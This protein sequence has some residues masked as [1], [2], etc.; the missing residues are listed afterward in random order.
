MEVDMT[1]DDRVYVTLSTETSDYIAE[2]F[3]V[4]A[5][6]EKLYQVG[7]I[8]YRD[9]KMYFIEYGWVKKLDVLENFHKEK[10]EDIVKYLTGLYKK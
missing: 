8:F 9:G 10:I 7:T 5:D 3:I 4:W 2:V 6:K 1:D